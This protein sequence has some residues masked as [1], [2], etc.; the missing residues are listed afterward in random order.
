LAALEILKE[1]ALL[2]FMHHTYLTKQARQGHL[3]RPIKGT[4]I[5]DEYD[6]GR[7]KC[8]VTIR[9]GAAAH[10]SKIMLTPS[11]LKAKSKA[12]LIRTLFSRAPKEL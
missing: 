12:Q 4:A 5:H 9:I 1:G 10:I 2:A 11:L 3:I 8:W 6:Y 7:G